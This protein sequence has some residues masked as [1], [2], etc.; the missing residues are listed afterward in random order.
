[1]S[2]LLFILIII[3]IV[4]K[5]DFK[6]IIVSNKKTYN[7]QIMII[8]VDIEHCLLPLPTKQNNNNLFYLFCHGYLIVYTVCPQ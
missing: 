5:L 4:I 2:K 7:I 8:I 1:M 3:N 6:T